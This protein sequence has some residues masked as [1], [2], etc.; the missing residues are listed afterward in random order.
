M[1]VIAWTIHVCLVGY[2]K[3][4]FASTKSREFRIFHAVEIGLVIL[5]MLYIYNQ[6]ATPE[7]SSW[8]I[9]LV[10]LGTLIVIDTLFFALFKKARKLFDL[11]HFA[12]AYGAIALVSVLYYWLA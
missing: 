3:K 10:I 4:Y 7:L 9:I 2:Y 6:F 8:Q 12:A 1:T 11:A 5:W